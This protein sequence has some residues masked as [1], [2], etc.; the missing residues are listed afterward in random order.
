M[1]DLTISGTWDL[2]PGSW[3]VGLGTWDLG[4]VAGVTGEEGGPPAPQILSPEFCLAADG[5]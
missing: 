3:E 2:G 1:K 5:S 4:G